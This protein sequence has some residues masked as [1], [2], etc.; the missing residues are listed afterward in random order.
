MYSDGLCFN[1]TEEHIWMDRAGFEEYQVGDRLEF[2][3]EVYEYVKTGHGKSL[4]Y[5]LRNPEDITRIE[6]CEEARR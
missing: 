1:K 6:E 2:Y 5:S 3:A 4:D